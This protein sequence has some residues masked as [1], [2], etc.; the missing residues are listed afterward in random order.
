MKFGTL[1]YRYHIMQTIESVYRKIKHGFEKYPLRSQD[2]P[3]P[4]EFLL[5]EMLYEKSELVMHMIES[6]IEKNFFQ[7]IIM[8]LYHKS[9]PFASTVLFQKI[10]KQVCGFKLKHFHSN[11]VNQTSCPK[12]TV[13]YNYNKKNNSLDLKLT[14]ESAITEYFAFR[15]YVKEHIDLGDL[16]SQPF[17]KKDPINQ[18]NERDSLKASLKNHE[19]LGKFV[20]ELKRYAAKQFEGEVNVMLYLTDGAD[21]TF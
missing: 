4:N 5:N 18:S 21:I 1:L 9:A 12:L 19:A 6:M 17:L 15:K 13:T 11:W 20:V 14:Q 10:F 8:E 7:R 2:V 3:N 16:L